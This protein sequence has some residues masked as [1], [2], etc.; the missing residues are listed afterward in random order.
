MMKIKILAAVALS[1]SFTTISEAVPVLQ[2]QSVGAGDRN[3]IGVLEKRFFDSL[4]SQGAEKTLRIFLTAAGSPEA[5][6][7]EITKQTQIVDQQCGKISEVQSVSER[8]LGSRFVQKRYVV[9]SKGCMI[10]WKL[11]YLR[12]AAGIWALNNFVFNT[13]ES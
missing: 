7:D 10:Y 8:A 4:E 6:T 3:Q 1:L 12:P 13:S 11:D 9:I 2:N 5:M